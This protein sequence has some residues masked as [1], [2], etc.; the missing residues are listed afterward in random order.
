[1]PTSGLIE[2]VAL[3]IVLS[4][5]DL[6]YIDVELHHQV[7][8]SRLEILDNLENNEYSDNI[9]EYTAGLYHPA[10]FSDFGD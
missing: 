3:Y 10:K 1:M 9:G 7:S 8:G 4:K 2:D 6:M 5:N